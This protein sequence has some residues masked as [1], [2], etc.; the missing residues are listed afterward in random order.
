MTKRKIDYHNICMK[1]KLKTKLRQEK[2]AH[3]YVENGCN[4]KQAYLEVNP[5]VTP[6]SAEV[7]A[8]RL[9]RKDKVISTILIDVEKIDARWI[10]EQFELERA[11]AERASDRIRCIENQA[12]ILGILRDTNININNANG[13]SGDEIKKIRDAIKSAEVIALDTVQRLDN[14]APPCPANDN[15]KAIEPDAS[16]PP[17]PSE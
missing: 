4:G 8:S 9:L 7:G 10:K 1:T 13:I 17:I 12:K 15:S 3:A 14:I 2:F 16:A 6:Q 5:G 11:K